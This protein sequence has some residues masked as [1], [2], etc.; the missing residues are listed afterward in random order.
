M[1]RHQRLSFGCGR[2]PFR[3]GD[4]LR[5]AASGSVAPE[6]ENKSIRG[7]QPL[8]MT[9]IGQG[10]D[11]T[12]TR[13]FTTIERRGPIA[14]VRYDRG[15]G[16][17]ALSRAA[18]REL[19]DIARMFRDDISAHVIVLTGTDKIFSAGAD[20]KDPEMAAGHDGGLMQR[21]HALRVGPDMCDAWEDLE[22]LT[23]CAVEGHCIGG[24]VALA[25]ACDIRIAARSASFRLPEIPLG[26]NMSWHSNPRLV[27]LMGP[28]R[29]KLF[30]ILGEAV[31][32]DQALDWRLVEEV[33]DDGAALDAALDLAQRAAAVPPVALRM[34]KQ[35]LDM[36][37]KALN[38]VATYMDR[39]QFA[40]AA[41]GKDQREAISAFL[42]KRAPRFTGE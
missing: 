39:D 28:A 42:E 19:T 21:R 4:F 35:S 33:V 22:Q 26:M 10:R 23:V 20:L 2:L 32:A 27:N 25:G 5:I 34:S 12:E 11:M 31:K 17:N 40:L 36:A 3:Q 8:R 24:G 1:A 37:A 18:M 30:V 38:P 9:P 7:R 13:E 16:I 29:A 14:I 6:F 15:D 41:T